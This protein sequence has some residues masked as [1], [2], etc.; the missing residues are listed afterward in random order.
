MA[1]HGKRQ[2]GVPDGG[3]G[4]MRAV[5]KAVGADVV[6]PSLLSSAELRQHAGWL[7]R[8]KENAVILELA[9]QGISIKEIVR[10]A[11]WKV[12]DAP[13][14][15]PR[16]GDLGLRLRRPVPGHQ[17][18]DAALRPAVHQACQQ[19]GEVGLRI[20]AVQLTGLNQ[21]RQAGPVLS[22]FVT[23]REQAVLSRQ[24]HRTHGA[25]HT[26]RV[27]LDASVFQKSFQPIPVVQRVAERFGGG[28][29][30]GQFLD[31]LS[32]WRRVRLSATLLPRTWSSIL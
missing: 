1:S 17:F 30:S 6:D 4:I 5:R 29:A 8:E 16:G 15:F 23:A 31:L 10:S 18:I 13:P 32:A 21:G 2:R 14:P 19:I 9:K 12:S 11:S 7:R 20:N 22:T 28:T 26:V 27:E 3:A 24:S 25:F